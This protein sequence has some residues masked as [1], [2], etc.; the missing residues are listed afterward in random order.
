MREIFD[1]DIHIYQFPDCDSDE[2]EEFK[3]QDLQLKVT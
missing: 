3:K 2:D 1:N